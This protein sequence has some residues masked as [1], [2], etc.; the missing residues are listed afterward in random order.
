MCECR[1]TSSFSM[2]EEDHRHLPL[3]STKESIVMVDICPNKIQGC[4]HSMRHRRFSKVTSCTSIYTEHLNS[5]NRNH[6]RS[7]SRSIPSSK[8]NL[9]VTNQP[10]LAL[11]LPIILLVRATRISLPTHVV[12]LIEAVVLRHPLRRL[13]GAGDLYES[14]RKALAAAA[15]TLACERAW[16][17]LAM[18]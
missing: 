9:S 17:D 13:T 16:D 14:R 7:E 8:H 10:V 12:E 6:Q 15:T 3:Q 2:D 4:T 18:I 1:D 5:E 11:L